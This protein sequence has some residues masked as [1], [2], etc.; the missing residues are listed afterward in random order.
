MELHIKDRIYFPQILAQQS[1]F[2]EFNLKRNILN[3]VAVNKEAQEKYNVKED[4]ENNRITWD[5]Q[6][7]TE[8]P[9]VVEFSKEELAYL[10]KNC[11]AIA[12]KPAPDDFWMVVEKI[13]NA[14]Q[15]TE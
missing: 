12:D 14:A 10:K 6:K 4:K 5:V 15:E 13:Y 8:E 1:N 2:L 7:D 3:K 9:L 11:E